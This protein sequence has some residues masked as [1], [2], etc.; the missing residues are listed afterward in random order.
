M[1][2][3]DL[4]AA[5][6]DLL[7]RRPAF[8]ASLTVY[9]HVVERWAE[10]EATVRPLDWPPALCRQRWERGVPLLAEADPGLSVEMVEEA[11]GPAVDLV[12]TVREDQAEA[13]QGFAQ[14]WDRGDITPQSLFP[15]RGRFAAVEDDLGLDPDVLAFLAIAG[16]RPLL[17]PYFAGCREHGEAPGWTLGV[18]PFCGAPPAFGD[19]IEDGRRQLACHLCG[20]GWIFSRLRCPFCGNDETKDLARLEVEATEEGYVIST[21]HTCRAYLKELDRR[22]RWNGGPALVE[23]WGSPHFDLV[24][25]Q[26]GYW[27]PAAPLILPPRSPAA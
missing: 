9:G 27:R 26:Q 19:I 21:C 8:A 13:L 25:I 24:A 17:E 22:V 11:L 12:L 16:L 5:W 10:A 7:R 2:D 1:P 18:C 15:S 4:R 14:A 3:L 23:D 6:A 20:G